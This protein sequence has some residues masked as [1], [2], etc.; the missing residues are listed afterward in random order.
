MHASL[1][2]NEGQS[3]V[4]I[5]IIYELII[6]LFH[7]QMMYILYFTYSTVCSFTRSSTLQSLCQPFSIPMLII[8]YYTM[9]LIFIIIIII[10]IPYYKNVFAHKRYY[11]AYEQ[12]ALHPF[13]P[14]DTN[15]HAYLI[16]RGSR[17]WRPIRDQ[18]FAV[19]ETV[20][21]HSI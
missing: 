15:A 21:F 16:L 12:Q 6:I 4:Y 10:I 5:S 13:Q 18:V 17:K 3:F 9:A 7:L 19:V 20:F 8:I 2:T 1:F 11:N 14:E